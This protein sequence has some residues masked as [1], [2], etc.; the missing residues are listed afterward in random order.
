M[1][2]DYKVGDIIK[3][4]VTGIEKYGIFVKADNDYYG[5]VHISEISDN[6]VKDIYS[7]VDINETIYCQIISVDKENKQLK[8]SIKNINY[9]EKIN[10]DFP[11]T[12]KGFLLLKENLPIWLDEKLKEYKKERR[13]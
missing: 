6:Y 5:L 2:D 4:E 8:L 12:R 1:Q 9:K 3:C 10:P 13:K 11:E 7:Y